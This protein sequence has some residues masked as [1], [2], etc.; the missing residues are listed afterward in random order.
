MDAAA[1]DDSAS[2]YGLQ[3]R[4]DKLARRGEYDRSVKLDRWQLI[5]VQ[6][7]RSAQSYCKPLRFVV[8]RAGKRVD[9]PV[10]MARD[11]RNDM[12]CGTEAVNAQPF[13][14]T[15]FDQAA[16]ADQSRAKKGRCLGVAIEIRD[17][18]TKPLVDYRE[19][20]ISTIEGVTGE[21]SFVAE[22][23]PIGFAVAA[24]ATSPAEPGNADASADG[25]SV[26]VRTGG[27]YGADNFVAEYQRNLRAVKLSVKDVKIGSANGARTHTDQKLTFGGRRNRDLRRC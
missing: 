11:L 8:A 5:A 6:S 25:K 19:L 17:R 1:D 7:R 4:R 21:S 12:S 26:G 16:V 2:I 14:I 20:R 22:I 24:N 23:F 10:L 15:G 9:F 13:G 3:S 27:F 18:K